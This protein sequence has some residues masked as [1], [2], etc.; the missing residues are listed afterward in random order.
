MDFITQHYIYIIFFIII[1]SIFAG[2]FFSKHH[3]HY[4]IKQGERI[5]K[6]IR[7][8]QGEN[9]DERIINYLR[10]INPFTFEELLLSLFK[11]N[12]C[13][14]KRNKRYTGD[15][16]IDGRFKYNGKWY[17]IQAKRYTNYIKS[18][19]VSKFST[20]CQTHK[21]RGL[22]IH[23]GKVGKASNQI[24]AN[25]PDIMIITPQDLITFIKTGRLQITKE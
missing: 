15:G 8:F 21:V 6:K 9:I 17:L 20:L 10:K 12:G 1:I 7:T 5:L 3:H 23:T 2:I 14:I 4:K 13:K 19:D 16:G 24:V 18:S 25:N 22:F 11:E